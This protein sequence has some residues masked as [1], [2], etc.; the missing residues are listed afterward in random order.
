MKIVITGVGRGLGR[1]LT[2]EFIQ[3]GHTV[4][5]CSQSP[6]RVAAIAQRFPAPNRFDVVDVT[7]L[8]ALQVWADA[9]VQREGPPDL[10]ICNAA[11]MNETRV[12][13]EVPA[14]E[15]EQ[16]VQVNIL[17]VFYTLKV[18]LPSMVAK[19]RGTIV[20]LSSGWGRSTSPEVAPYCA[21]KYAVEG[22][23]LALASE[24]PAGMVAVP[25]NPGII[26]TDMLR[27]CFADEASQY[28][29]P[30]E[31]AKKAVPFLLGL[32]KRHHGTS[33]TVPGV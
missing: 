25:L 6:T 11:I 3:Q 4:F 21:S 32:G 18:F 5:G 15:F 2:D 28:P 17:G 33:Q 30:K 20:T 9:L 22:M 26:D 14:E 13:W 19:Q 7:S 23:T 10:L 31:W 8:V 16:L 24:L 27:K 1:A 12:L 29:V